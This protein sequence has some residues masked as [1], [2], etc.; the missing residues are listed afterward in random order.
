MSRSFCSPKLSLESW[1]YIAFAR[2]FPEYPPNITIRISIIVYLITQC[3]SWLKNN[4]LYRFSNSCLTLFLLMPKEWKPLLTRNGWWRWWTRPTQAPNFVISNQDFHI[5]FLK[6]WSTWKIHE[7]LTFNENH[8]KMAYLRK[9]REG[10][11]SPLKTG[12]LEQMSVKLAL[13][14]SILTTS[15]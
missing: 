2:S 7:C 9:K 3:F 12:E 4:K 15:N 11:N 8:R 1:I 13:N 14:G 10:G 5:K 6:M